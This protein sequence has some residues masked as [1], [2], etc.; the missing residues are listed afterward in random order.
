MMGFPPQ[1]A[2]LSYIQNNTHQMDMS[3]L[4]S[5]Y[6]TDRLMKTLISS[7]PLIHFHT[8]TRIQC[9]LFP[10][11]SRLLHCCCFYTCFQCVVAFFG[12]VF[13]SADTFDACAPPPPAP[14]PVVH[15]YDHVVSLYVQLHGSPSTAL[16]GASFFYIP[17]WQQQGC[18][19]RQ[20][21]T[22]SPDLI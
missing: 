4:P 8:S 18:E 1:F 7:Q 15:K 17:S 3:T 6:R 5:H 20:E 13:L 14:I 16:S 9:A 11:S 21:G 22:W 10:P 12:G 19:S 2:F